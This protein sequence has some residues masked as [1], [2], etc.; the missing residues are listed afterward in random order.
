MP[1]SRPPSAQCCLMALI[2]TQ[3][4][5]FAVTRGIARY[6]FLC[7]HS[8]RCFSLFHAAARCHFFV[9][10]LPAI[11]TPPARPSPRHYHHLLTIVAAHHLLLCSFFYV[12]CHYFS[13]LFQ[14][15]RH[16]AA[17]C[18]FSPI[19][20]AMPPLFC[21]PAAFFTYGHA[22]CDAP[23]YFHSRQRYAA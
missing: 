12:I 6:V 16:A 3:M 15:Y 7:L 18:H 22:I 23:L 10:R 4:R 8:T 17:D 5:H 14:H 19:P 11:T 21:W 1:F 13:L 9:A 2:A 20:Y